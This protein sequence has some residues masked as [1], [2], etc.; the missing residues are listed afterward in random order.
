[1]ERPLKELKAFTRTAVPAGETRTVHFELPISRLAYYNEDDQQFE[2]EAIE[3]EAFVGA[4]SL[5]PNALT[6]RFLVLSLT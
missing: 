4:N 3:Y 1:M 2:V 6:A 5:D